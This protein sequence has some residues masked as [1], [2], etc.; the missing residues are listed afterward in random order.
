MPTRPFYVQ[1]NGDCIPL[2]GAWRVR[3][4]E[5]DW[6]VLGHHSVV[7]CGSERAA[8]SMLEELEAQS[9][10]DALANEALAVLED[11]ADRARTRG[12]G[13]SNVTAANDGA[14][15]FDRVDLVAR[16][17]LEVR[18]PIRVAE[19]DVLRHLER[20]ALRRRVACAE[21]KFRAWGVVPVT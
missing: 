19:D 1:R 16:R 2:E 12:G 21:I 14:I 7:P 9:D 6:L 3:Q 18:R 4:I 20:E 11:L 10:V 13:K 17:L 8:L 5:G 15:S